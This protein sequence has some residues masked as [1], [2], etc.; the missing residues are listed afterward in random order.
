MRTKSCEQGDGAEESRSQPSSGLLES[1]DKSFSIANSAP[2]ELERSNFL[3]ILL[4]LGLTSHESCR[5][6]RSDLSALSCKDP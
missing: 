6:E 3:V 1:A 5:K 2:S 4:F